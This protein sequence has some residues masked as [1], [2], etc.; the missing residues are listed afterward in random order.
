MRFPAVRLALLC[1]LGPAAA[2]AA[3]ETPR[4]TLPS[5]NAILG[6]GEAFGF[7]A[8]W[9]IF[10]RAGR[11]DISAAPPDGKTAADERRVIVRIASDGTIG[12]LHRYEAVGETLYATDTGLMRSA[13]YRARAGSKNQ[14]R[15]LLFDYTARVAHYTDALEPARDATVALPDGE[16]LD[17]VT[18]L[19]TARRWQ[20]APGDTREILVQ[21]DK[22]FYPLLLRAGAV[23]TVRTRR[24]EFSALVITPEPVGKPS[25]LFKR[26][27]SLK[28]W[29]EDSPARLP[30]RVE[31]KGRFGTVTADLVD[32]SPPASASVS[33][34]PAPASSAPSI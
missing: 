9:G 11:I 13:S 28:I 18:S 1:L 27:G 22:K 32:Y 14:Q 5:T 3:S 34:T 10:P 15:A 25:G 24:G 17:L 19:V 4:E 7:Q 23:E 26:G 21:V 12:R 6:P 2:F 30:L 33:A 29:I 8:S 16:P 20:L 31:V